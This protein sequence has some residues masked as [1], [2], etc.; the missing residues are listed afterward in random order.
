MFLLRPGS[1]VLQFHTQVGARG[2]NRKN[3][4]HLG[5]WTGLGVRCPLTASLVWRPE[6]GGLG[7]IIY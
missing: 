5:F 6:N 2:G 7:I 1:T 4:L 3:G